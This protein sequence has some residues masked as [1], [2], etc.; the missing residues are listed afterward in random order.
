MLSSC[1]D[2]CFV[3]VMFLMSFPKTEEYVSYFINS[4]MLN[5]VNI[6]RQY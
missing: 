4:T 5:T 1:V 3:I 6:V 2:G